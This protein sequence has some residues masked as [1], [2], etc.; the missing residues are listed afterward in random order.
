M[1]WRET[2]LE[3]WRTIDIY[4]C[5]LCWREVHKSQLIESVEDFRR[6]LRHI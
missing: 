5:P 2:K 4:V 1:P 3:G 6:E